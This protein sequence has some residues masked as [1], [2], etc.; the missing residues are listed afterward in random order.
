[1]GQEYLVHNGK[2]G[3]VHIDAFT[4]EWQ[5]LMKGF[6]PRFT[7]HDLKAKGISDDTGDKQ[8]GSGHRS[9]SMINVYDRKPNIVT[10]IK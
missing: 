3:K 7:F 1:M 8:K 6:E 10:P 9:A 5:R 2:G 4:T